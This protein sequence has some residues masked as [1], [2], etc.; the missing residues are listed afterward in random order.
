MNSTGKYSLRISQLKINEKKFCEFLTGY[1]FSPL[2]LNRI[3]PKTR[4]YGT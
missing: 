3:N 2:E 4:K 1:Y